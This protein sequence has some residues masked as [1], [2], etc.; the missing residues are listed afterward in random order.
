[1]IFRSMAITKSCRDMPNIL[2]GPRAWWIQVSY[3]RL[4][5]P[6]RHRRVARL[7]PNKFLHRGQRYK[8]WQC[9]T[10]AK[11]IRRIDNNSYTSWSRK[12]KVKW[13]AC[14]QT[15]PASRSAGLENFKV[16]VSKRMLINN[17]IKIIQKCFCNQVMFNQRRQKIMPIQMDIMK[18][19]LD[20][21]AA[22]QFNRNMRI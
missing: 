14:Y 21:L 7:Q 10:S 9:R 17:Q 3:L 1:M 4:M 5:N 11:C 13:R 6:I 2:M 22:K 8:A 15:K 16:R 19:K 18:N 12:L 20:L